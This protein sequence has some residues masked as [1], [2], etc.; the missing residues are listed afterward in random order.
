MAHLAHAFAVHQS[1]ARYHLGA[2]GI[3]GGQGIAVLLERALK[4][5]QIYNNA[6][7][8]EKENPI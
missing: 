2:A 7:K 6:E 4:T 8:K 5:E 1:N 3:G